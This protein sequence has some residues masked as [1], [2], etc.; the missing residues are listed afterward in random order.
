LVSIG[1]DRSVLGLLSLFLLL[2]WGSSITTDGLQSFEFK[3]SDV[4]VS[5]RGLILLHLNE[6]GFLGVEGGMLFGSARG[7]CI[8]H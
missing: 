2:W 1:V 6:E 8:N 5:L 7:V 3:D 4:N